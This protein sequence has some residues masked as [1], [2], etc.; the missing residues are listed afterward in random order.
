MNARRKLQGE[1]IAPEETSYLIEDVEQLVNA[2]FEAR[3]KNEPF[4][5]EVNG[6]LPEMNLVNGLPKTPV[7]IN[8]IERSVLQPYP[9]VRD[10]IGMDLQFQFPLASDKSNPMNA[11]LKWSDDIHCRL[12]IIDNRP[13]M[14]IE[15]QG[16]TLDVT[17]TDK[18]TML[19]YLETIG[20]P[21]G[22]WG[23]EP[24]DI[25][26]LVRDLSGSRQYSMSRRTKEMIDLGTTVELTHSAL[27]VTD[28]HGE[29][30]LE[31]E[32]CINV[33]HVSQPSRFEN[34][35]LLSPRTYRNMLRFV[36]SNDD[37]SWQYRAAYSGHMVTG[38]LIE[39]AVQ[40]NPK[41][42][43]PNGKVIDKVLHALSQKPL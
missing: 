8:R 37:M 5:V 1:T 26:H 41:L 25:R 19:S 9:G 6:Y 30:D 40:D 35:E 34:D 29:K 21:A 42:G 31:Q 24:K 7:G 13:L 12:A 17:G 4:L 43:I 2:E 39:E 18:E 38:E 28:A 3:L 11:L 22:I 15:S 36:R 20:L 23:N 14:M 10:F 32:L 27:Y 33:D 16:R